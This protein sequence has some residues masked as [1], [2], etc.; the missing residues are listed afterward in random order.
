MKFS[1]KQTVVLSILSAI[2]LAFI[3][4]YAVNMPQA[5]ARA[6][7]YAMKPSGL[8]GDEG[9]WSD[10]VPLAEWR[11]V[12]TDAG[13]IPD[14]IDVGIA[15]VPP[16]DDLITRALR[17]CIRDTC[18]AWEPTRPSASPDAGGSH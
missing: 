15:A 2:L 14:P 7:V 12:P 6:P 16:V 11:S 5:G 13:V 8:D 3:I 10:P 9:S 17:G 1:E 18:P 4:V